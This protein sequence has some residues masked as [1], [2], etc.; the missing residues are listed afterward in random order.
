MSEMGKHNGS[1]TESLVE[2]TFK[3]FEVATIDDA[4]IHS[5]GD[6]INSFEDRVG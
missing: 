6:I 3:G 5:I 4:R 2:Q 1:C